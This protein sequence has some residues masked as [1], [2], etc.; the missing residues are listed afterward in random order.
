[1]DGSAGRADWP[2][3]FFVGY[4]PLPAKHLLRG[5]TRAV[6]VWI[7]VFVL[8]GD[9]ASLPACALLFMLT[10]RAVALL[11]RWW[12]GLRASDACLRS[13]FVGAAAVRGWRR[14]DMLHLP[15]HLVRRVIGCTLDY[16]LPPAAFF[17]RVAPWWAFA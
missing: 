13:T 17:V 8:A 1:V 11:I 2:A 7:F 14:A 6:C 3:T 10:L 4:S 15:T 16:L 12:C 9:A 5:I